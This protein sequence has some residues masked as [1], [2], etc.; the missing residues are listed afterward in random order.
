MNSKHLCLIV[1][2]VNFIHCKFHTII[3]H[4]YF[5]YFGRFRTRKDRV[6][7]WVHEELV[8]K[9][10]YSSNAIEAKWSVLKRW[11]EKTR[12]GELP[13]NNNRADWRK[14]VHEFHY[15]KIMGEGHSCDGGH[16]FMFPLRSFCETL[17]MYSKVP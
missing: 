2:S 1:M 4:C 14:L 10:G 16:T 6:P 5:N 13:S 3:F 15:R 11:I 7:C 8:N 17:A 12:G 9:H